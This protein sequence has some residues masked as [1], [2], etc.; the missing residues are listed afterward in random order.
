MKKE[1]WVRIA[2]SSAVLMFGMMISFWFDAS[3]GIKFEPGVST[4]AMGGHYASYVLWGMAAG[5]LI[6]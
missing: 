5:I 3:Q 4:L 1:K 6:G 2:L